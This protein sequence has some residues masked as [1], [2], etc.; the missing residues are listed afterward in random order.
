MDHPGAL[1]VWTSAGLSYSNVARALFIAGRGLIRY[2]LKTLIWVRL[3]GK[4]SL[5]GVRQR[6][7]SGAHRPLELLA[8]PAAHDPS[9]VL[10]AK[11]GQFFGKQSD[12]LPIRVTH[13]R[14]I[15]SP[16][17]SLWSEG[18]GSGP[19]HLALHP[20]L[21]VLYCVNELAGTLAAFAI[22]NETG[23][24]AEMQYEAL[25]SPGSGEMPGPR[26]CT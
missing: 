6:Y 7:L 18:V 10:I 9:F 23:A 17:Y 22:E 21:N 26:T 19:R 16:E 20:R 11:P 4:V 13:P 8:K 14:N 5:S 15:G 2:G 12:H 1:S 25:T 3:A 24:L